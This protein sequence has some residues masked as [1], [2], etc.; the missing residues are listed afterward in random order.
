[1]EW[2]QY[3]KL[4]IYKYY[5]IFYFIQRHANNF[6]SNLY[7]SWVLY[8]ELGFPDGSLTKKL[9]PTQEHRSCRRL[10]FNPWVRNISLEGEMEPT[11]LGNPIDRGAWWTTQ[12]MGSQ[13]IGQL[14]NWA[15]SRAYIELGKNEDLKEVNSI[16]QEQSKFV[17]NSLENYQMP[18][19]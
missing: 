8:I 3:Q 2:K 14:S 4:H 5:I 11:P 9:L 18:E 1:M 17:C 19:N 16:C 7:L 10:R 15:G 12:S 6:K 13:R